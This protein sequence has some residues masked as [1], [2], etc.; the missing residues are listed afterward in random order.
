MENLSNEKKFGKNL[1]LFSLC[2]W[3]LRTE[4]SNIKIALRI[5]FKNLNCFAP[6]AGPDGS[7]KSNKKSY[8]NSHP[9]VLLRGNQ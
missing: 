8:K 9:A 5:F 6:K 1:H 4:Y 3:I 2:V 7:G